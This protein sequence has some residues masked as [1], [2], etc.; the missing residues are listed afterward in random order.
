M[1][2]FMSGWNSTPVSV[3]I[4]AFS[5]SSGSS[6]ILSIASGLSAARIPYE[7]PI[8][9]VDVGGG[10]VLAVFFQIFILKFRIFRSSVSPPEV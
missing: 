3:S 10:L 7:L 4:T 1:E 2:T 9:C 6:V 5:I 8:A